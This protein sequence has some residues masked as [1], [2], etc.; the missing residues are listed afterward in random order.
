MVKLRIDTRLDRFHVVFREQQKIRRD[1][2]AIL[3][4]E[5]FDAFLVRNLNVEVSH[6]APP[7]RV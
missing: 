6:H 2:V 4:A 3:V 7:L 5:Q 1:T